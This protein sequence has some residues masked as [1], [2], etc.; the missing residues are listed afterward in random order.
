MYCKSCFKPFV[1]EE[2]ISQ[3]IIF[4]AN[5]K[6]LGRKCFVGEKGTRGDD[7]GGGY[8]LTNESLHNFNWKL[9]TKLGNWKGPVLPRNLVG[10][11]KSWDIR[12]CIIRTFAERQC[13][14]LVQFHHQRLAAPID[15]KSIGSSLGIRKV[16]KLSSRSY[17]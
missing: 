1:L 13:A 12:I 15:I 4:L 7:S 9:S 6:E 10:G 17:V 5:V 11:W 16:R 14:L 2:I 8:I 3:I